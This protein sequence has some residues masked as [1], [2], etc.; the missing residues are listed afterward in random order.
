MP[1]TRIAKAKYVTTDYLS[2]EKSEDN[3][4]AKF[5]KET[6]QLSHKDVKVSFK[7]V[8]EDTTGKEI[9]NHAQISK[10]T[11]SN[12]K[13]GTDIDSTPDKWI[14]GEDDQDIEKVKLTYA[15]LALRKFITKINNEVVNPITIPSTI[16]GALM[17]LFVAPTYFMI[18]ISLLLAWTVNFIVLLIII[19]EI[20][21]SNAPIE[22]NAIRI[23]FFTLFNPVIVSCFVI[24]HGLPFSSFFTLSNCCNI[25]IT[26]DDFSKSVNV[27]VNDAG[28]GWFD[29]VYE[30][31]TTFAVSPKFSL[32]FL[33]YGV[34]SMACNEW[35]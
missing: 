24:T 2:K 29:S 19:V 7:V 11:D 9:I 28:N 21:I 17:K 22:K 26:S 31:N 1:A 13:T 10:E 5:N 4:I 3:L 27:T 18:E 34:V 15:D 32:S 14:D 20:T 33:Q 25:A 35:K 12:G 8:S 23:P 16:N 30:F 6:K